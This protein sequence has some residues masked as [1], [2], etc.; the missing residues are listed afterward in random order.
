MQHLD[1]LFVVVL[2]VLCL[3]HKIP[4]EKLHFPSKRNEDMGSEQS[5]NRKMINSSEKK[6]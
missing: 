6:K 4:L 5:K 3:R 1:P 2:E